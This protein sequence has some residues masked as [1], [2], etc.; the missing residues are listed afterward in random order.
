ML[1]FSLFSIFLNLSLNSRKVYIYLS[2]ITLPDAFFVFLLFLYFILSESLNLAEDQMEIM[3]EEL[4]NKIS[5]N[6]IENEKSL[7]TMK[8]N[9]LNSHKQNLWDKEAIHISHIESLKL[10]NNR[11]IEKLKIS[12]RVAIEELTNS[13]HEKMSIQNKNFELQV[14]GGEEVRTSKYKDLIVQHQLQMEEIK[15]VK[16][17]HVIPILTKNTQI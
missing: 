5:S 10:D 14:E 11:E 8:E 7:Q 16:K 9:L 4:K 1:I 17:N 2:V 13:F 12:Q 15:K 3:R 6:Q